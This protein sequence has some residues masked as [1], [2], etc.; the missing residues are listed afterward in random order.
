MNAI[1]TDIEKREWPK[2]INGTGDDQD[3]GGGTLIL[4]LRSNVVFNLCVHGLM[5]SAAVMKHSFFHQSS[6]SIIF[7][8]QKS[9]LWFNHF[10]WIELKLSPLNGTCAYTQFRC[11][12][13]SFVR[14]RFYLFYLYATLIF[15]SI[16][17]LFTQFTA[18]PRHVQ[19]QFSK[20]SF[21]Y[22]SIQC[23]RFAVAMLATA[24]SIQLSWL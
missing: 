18:T 13:R 7:F 12:L 22:P 16:Y 5:C 1:K 14:I 8:F 15:F 4:Y 10:F 23:N 17:L 2:S 9:S 11:R 21:T 3:G 19:Y 6:F 24:L 20:M